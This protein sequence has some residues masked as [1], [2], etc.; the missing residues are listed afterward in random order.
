MGFLVFTCR[1]RHF[2]AVHGE[3]SGTVWPKWKRVL[4]SIGDVGFGSLVR[5]M[6]ICKPYI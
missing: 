3:N 1:L 6:V 5:S 2:V 4:R